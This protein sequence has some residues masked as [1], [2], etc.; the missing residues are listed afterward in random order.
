LN[1]YKSKK[2]SW[3][4]KVIMTIDD[5]HSMI[6]NPFETFKKL[7]INILLMNWEFSNISVS[8]NYLINKVRGWLPNE[9]NYKNHTEDSII[10]NWKIFN[11]KILKN[12]WYIFFPS[13]I[14]GG[15]CWIT[16]KII[17]LK[18]IRKYLNELKEAGHTSFEI[19]WDDDKLLLGEDISS[20]SKSFPTSTFWLGKT[21]FVTKT[22]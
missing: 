19:S 10:L 16:S 15:I 7:P 22:V 6:N 13:A 14:D 3:I 8:W 4:K 9:Q 12:K 20:L 2:N 21:S 11:K 1:N 18:S 5:I 17:E